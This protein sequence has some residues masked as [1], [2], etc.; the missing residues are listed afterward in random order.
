MIYTVTLNPALDD[1]MQVEHFAKGQLN[2]AK[3]AQLFPGG[4]GINVSLVLDQ[5]GMKSTALGFVAGDTGTML[6]NMLAKT[7]VHC[8]FIHVMGGS[9]RINIKIH[10]DDD[11]EING[12]GPLV[13][14]YD[15]Q[16]LLKRVKAMHKTDVLVLSGSCAPG[17]GN[18]VY[19]RIMQ[20]APKGMKIIVD[21]EKKLLE[22]VLPFHPFLIK[23]NRPEMEALTG[24][25]MEHLDDVLEGAAFLQEKGAENVLVS[26]G[27]DGA[28][29]MSADGQ[30]Y[31]RKAASGKVVNPTGAGD[32][33]VAGFL[34]GYL[35]QKSFEG[36]LTLGTA[37]GGAA[38]F[39]SGLCTA[40]KIDD[41]LAQM[42]QEE[43]EL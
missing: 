3:S 5:L 12:P 38:A 31:Q 28:V 18:D 34:F 4:K 14:E 40:E 33:M 39:S 37:C 7:G 41:V 6:E 11:T 15:L 13:E 27:E 8:E 20:K 19:A 43:A 1:V 9:T 16:D 32:S 29:L 22:P 21:A 25:K 36:A 2:R 35:V 10:D 30:V 24:R 42:A 26:L 17:L 23:P